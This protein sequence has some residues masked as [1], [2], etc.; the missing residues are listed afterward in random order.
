MSTISK[1]RTFSEMN[2]ETN[3]NNNETNNNTK[4][5]Q[6]IKSETP[7]DTSIKP[8]SFQYNNNEFPCS[9]ISEIELLIFNNNNE[10][11]N[12]LQ[13]NIINYLCKIGICIPCIYRICNKFQ[14][15]SKQQNCNNILISL[16]KMEQKTNS[17]IHKE[18]KLEIKLENNENNTQYKN[19]FICND[20]YLKLY[21]SIQNNKFLSLSSINNYEYK[22]Y[23]LTLKI[24]PIL[25]IRDFY[26]I[27]H[28][29]YN[30]KQSIEIIILPNYENIND[31]YCSH[32]DLIHFMIENLSKQLN[33]INNKN[34]NENNNNT[35]NENNNEIRNKFG[36]T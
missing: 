9:L 27:H 29:H 10:T 34:E 30:I 11:S 31:N 23:Y 15:I 19:C 28:L 5:K 24:P 1:K 17:L 25:T 26:I 4:I 13:H 6:E 12:K 32:K 36:Y 14:S 8:I 35:E 2:N 21:E 33:I 20:M 18:I 7:E 16:F 3:D 22:S